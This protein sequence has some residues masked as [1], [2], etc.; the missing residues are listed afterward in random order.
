MKK[1]I[2]TIKLLI[3]ISSCTIAQW[4]ILNEG[5]KGSFN[6]IDFV[7][8]NTGWIAGSNGTLLKTTDGGE[9]WFT[10]PL[11][12]SWNINQIDFI[13]DSVGVAVGNISILSYYY[14]IIIKTIDGGNNWVMQ[15]QIPEIDLN[16]ICIID[17]NN[18]CAI[19]YNKVY[20]TSNGGSDWYDLSP[21]SPNSIDRY[22][23][24][25]MW[26]PNPD[27]G[28]VV[29]YYEHQN[30][31]YSITNI[32]VIMRTTNRGTSWEEKIINQFRNITDLQFIDDTTGYFTAYSITGMNHLYKTTDICKTWK[33]ITSDSSSVLLYQFLD[34]NTAYAVGINYAGR[35]NSPDNIIMKSSDGGV[36][37]LNIQYFQGQFSKIYFCNKNVGYLFGPFVLFK[38]T[39][40]GYN[41][42]TIMSSYTLADTY[43]INKKEGFAGGMGESVGHFSYYFMLSTNNGG[44]SWNRGN[45]FPGV[46]QSITFLNDSL[47]FHIASG[48]FG[49]CGGIYKTSDTVNNWNQVSKYIYDDYSFDGND[50]CFNN[51]KNGWAV[52]FCF[53]GTAYRPAVLKTIDGGSS[54]ELEWI[55]PIGKQ[56]GWASNSLHSIC[57]CE[58]TAWA[59]GENGMIVK[60]TSQNGWKEQTSI[61]D[62][63]L[64]KVFFLNDNCGWISGGYFNSNNLKSILLKTTNSGENWE[65]RNLDYLI[66]DIWFVSNQHGLAVG[67]D[68]SWKGI[69]LESEDGG[70]NWEV[71]VDSLLGPLNSISVKDNYAWAVGTYGLVLRTTNLGV[72]WIDD[73]KNKVY[74]TEF[75]L[76]QNYPNPF[77]PATKIRYSIPTDIH[78][79]LKIYDILGRE[80]AKLVNEEKSPGNYEVVFNMQQTTNYKQL[81]SGVYFFRLTAG[82]YTATKKM[83]LLK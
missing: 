42:E 57:R 47:G 76:E 17:E 61:T 19:G 52:G 39:D 54:W 49:G 71:A 36:S 65:T 28:L 72:T 32:G 60:Y 25:S 12:E 3:L 83:L 80:V 48:S 11:D 69:I 73:E 79:K 67:C 31:D 77:N 81:T 30:A 20:K 18:I 37:W 2:L 24:N 5:F 7:N 53:K 46:F 63:P 34:I 50:I 78:V 21:N 27:T 4:E 38:S 9:N 82:N 41:W 29:G 16:S 22:Y 43:F 1:F 35:T 58:T 64:N 26:F 44:N 68:K 6:T 59:V 13:N 8:E 62:L 51:D 33:M 55:G 10:I 15:K 75:K 45:V 70:D 66:N 14:A 74:P 56:E 23:Y 40:S